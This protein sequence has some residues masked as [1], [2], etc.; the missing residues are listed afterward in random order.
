[1]ADGTEETVPSGEMEVIP[2]LDPRAPESTLPLPA[3]TPSDAPP[4]PP[5]QRGRES[6]QGGL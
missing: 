6:H 1:M 2:A 4:A 5:P 3:F